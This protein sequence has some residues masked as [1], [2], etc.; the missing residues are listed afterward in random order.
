MG[1]AL[2][3]IAPILLIVFKCCFEAISSVLL[4]PS[5]LPVLPEA[6]RCS[7]V[8]AVVVVVAVVIAFGLVVVEELDEFEVLVE[9]DGIDDGF[10]VVLARL[11]DELEDELMMVAV[12][13]VLSFV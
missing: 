12:P 6:G 10:A 8:V 1:P 4:W 3:S 7:I 13:V 5:S 2:P 11:D 9:G